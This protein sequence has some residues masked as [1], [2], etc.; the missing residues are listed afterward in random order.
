MC[1]LSR[2]VVF[3]FNISFQNN[4]HFEEL[5]HWYEVFVKIKSSYLWKLNDFAK[6]IYKT[7]VVTLSQNLIMFSYLC[8]FTCVHLTFS[9]ENWVPLWPLLGGHERCCTFQYL[10]W[11]DSV[12]P[13]LQF[14]FFILVW[15]LSRGR[16][17]TRIFILCFL[18]G[19]I[20]TWRVLSERPRYM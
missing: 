16:L 19:I 5:S 18:H 11:T 15:L 4:K 8:I 20:I 12:K 17:F 10:S 3:S 1:I 14:S 2:F 9:I 6:T 13:S 7:G